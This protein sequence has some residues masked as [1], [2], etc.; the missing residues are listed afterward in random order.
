MKPCQLAIEGHHGYMVYAHPQSPTPARD[1]AFFEVL[2][3]DMHDKRERWGKETTWGPYRPA[4]GTISQI[5]LNIC[6]GGP[7]NTVASLFYMVVAKSNLHQTSNDGWI[8]L[9]KVKGYRNFGAGV[10]WAFSITTV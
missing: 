5:E 3:S 6:R 1:L 2:P 8:R 9:T 7:A 10:S 4:V